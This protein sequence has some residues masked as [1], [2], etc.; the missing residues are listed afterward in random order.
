MTIDGKTVQSLKEVVK[1][2]PK[3]KLDKEFDNGTLID[4]SNLTDSDIKNLELLGRVWGFLKYYHPAI[5]TGNYN[6]DYELFR[7]LFIP[8]GQCAIEGV[9][10]PPSYVKCLYSLKGVLLTFAQ[11]MR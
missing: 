4:L 11:L 5:A 1:D 6:W 7:F 8:F 10:I 3:A 2:L 9:A